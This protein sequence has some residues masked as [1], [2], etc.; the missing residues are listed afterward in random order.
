[1]SNAAKLIEAEKLARKQ[2]LLPLAEAFHKLLKETL[3]PHN[4]FVNIKLDNNPAYQ[5]TPHADWHPLFIPA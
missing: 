1:M 3:F 2:G 4:P 5:I